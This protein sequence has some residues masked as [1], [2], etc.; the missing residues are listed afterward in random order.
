VQAEMQGADL[1]YADMRGASLFLTKVQGATFEGAKLQG[2]DLDHAD[3]RG[4]NFKGASLAYSNLSR[5]MIWRARDAKCEGAYVSQIDESA[6]AEPITK[7]IEESVHEIP[8]DA[9]K[10]QATDRLRAGLIVDGDGKS[11]IQEAWGKCEQIS[12]LTSKDDFSESVAAVMVDL[13]CHTRRNPGVIAIGIVNA[14]K[15]RYDAGPFLARFSAGVLGEDGKPCGASGGLDEAT[16]ESLRELIPDA[17]AVLASPASKQKP[18]P[19]PTGARS[20]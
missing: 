2:A 20:N 8:D 19:Q 3:L 11:A 17:G 5:A 16:K 13:V 14:R 4:A 10:R 12:K 7:F 15:E 18:S 6:M 1:T 9:Q